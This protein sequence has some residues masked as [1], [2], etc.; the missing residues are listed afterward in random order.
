VS[1]V[2]I[3][4]VVQDETGRWHALVPVVHGSDDVA[5]R[6]SLA[7]LASERARVDVQGVERELTIYRDARDTHDAFVVWDEALPS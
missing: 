5:V 1:P 2:A 6:D 4:P 7:G 3:I